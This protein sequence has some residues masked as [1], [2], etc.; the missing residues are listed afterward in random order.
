[1]T[2][3]TER[4]RYYVEYHSKIN[5]IS[6]SVQVPTSGV[7]CTI[8]SQAIDL[9]PT[10]HHGQDAVAIPDENTERIVLPA[11]VMPTRTTL[12][13]ASSQSSLLTLKLTAL[14]NAPLSSP[15]SLLTSISATEFPLAPLPATQLQGFENLAC[16][17]CGN[18]L[19][20]RDGGIDLNEEGPIKRVVDLP[21][22]HWQEL[23][24]CWMCHEE[25]Y[26]ELREGDLGARL[27]Q[28]L[29]G[30]TYVLIHAENVEQGAVAIEEDACAIDWAK[31]I[32]RRWRPLGCSRC[33]H[34]IGDGWYQSR[35]ED[36]TD[37][38]MIQAKFHKYAV[39]FKG[40]DEKS[41]MNLSVP[42]Q[43][44]ASYVAAEIFE[45]ARHHATYRFILQD[46]LDGQDMMLEP[47][48]DNQITWDLSLE[49]DL[50]TSSVSEHKRGKKVMKVL[51]LEALAEEQEV[52]KESYPKEIALWDNWR[53]D[54]GVE[55]LQFN[56]GLLLGLLTM[57]EQSSSC[58]PP[59]LNNAASAVLAMN[60]M[61][62]GRWFFKDALQPRN[63][64]SFKQ[65]IPQ[66][67]MDP[68]KK[69]VGFAPDHDI[70]TAD[71]PSPGSSKSNS[72]VNSPKSA[73]S[74][75]P[76]LSN[77]TISTPNTASAAT[78]APQ[79]IST[80]GARSSYEPMKSSYEEQWGLAD[81]GSKANKSGSP[82]DGP[83]FPNKDQQGGSNKKDNKSK[84]N[85]TIS[86]S[87][88]KDKASGLGIQANVITASATDGTQ[89]GGPN[90]AGS[91]S[92]GGPS[93]GGG[94]SKA[95]GSQ[96]PS[97]PSQKSMTK[98]ERRE[99][100][101]RKIAE[102]AARVSAG[103]PASGKKAAQVA[104]QPNSGFSPN[105]SKSL[106]T[107][108]PGAEAE[109]AIAAAESTSQAK[110]RE[111]L[112][113]EMGLFAHLD[114]PKFANTASA[115]KDLHPAVV[116]VGLQMAQFK[117][118]GANARCVAT[119]S[120]FRK[121]IQDYQTPP[122][123]TLS[124]NMLTYLSPHISYL[125]TCRPMAVSMGNAIR[126]LKYEIGK[127]LEVPDEDA[128]ALFLEKIDN[129][130]R[131]RITMADQ[132]ITS[133]GLQK[134]QDGDVI[135]TYARSSV[136]Q[137]LLLAAHEKGIKFK[138]IVVDSRPR[139]EGKQLLR[140]LA[141]AGVPCT[142][143]LLTA[144]GHVM[145]EVSKVILGAHSLLSNGA[146]YSRAGTAV[147][148]MS[149]H[150]RKIPVI[151]CCE[152]YKFSDRVQLDSFVQNEIGNPD[153]LV[154]DHNNNYGHSSTRFHE[155]VHGNSSGA[156]SSA[157]VLSGWKESR[158]L[159]LL[160]LLYDL[161]PSEF[162]TVVITEVGLIPCTSV[163]VILREFL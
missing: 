152:T 11:R 153:E 104:A 161:T 75:T 91:S 102:K 157:G 83:G 144:I 2:Q 137:D 138:V 29:I 14:P 101:E 97:A 49:S 110:K 158:D 21:S 46:R 154:N 13:P 115:P 148:A 54:P 139:F 73:L 58:L 36:G 128:R 122:N 4:L 18:V 53:G 86:T 7:T 24:D 48:Y 66:A 9:F 40:R 96:K 100:Q 129:F 89:S 31:G 65:D 43:R 145:R 17:C 8:G 87:G 59:A 146:L 119:L 44:F 61:R 141:S 23:V 93:S 114:P 50:C 26:T 130:I 84:R 51:Y 79:S 111:K 151:V 85:S 32:K 160:N 15:S 116:N 20:K 90:S 163:P 95:G 37:L 28:A 60:S 10:N 5:S 45:S 55:K 117:I 112:T 56:K 64:T 42:K 106:A 72:A 80:T 159:K 121:A 118:C 162:V 34:P 132:V 92:A 155:S 27:G 1:M 88:G 33:M 134:I 47:I 63:S 127:N 149:A 136:V 98:A 71:L 22:E 81:R 113:K 82:R 103:L 142:Y 147:V 143:V 140:A 126:Y 30:G 150:E 124:R 109:K 77:S 131:D 68:K 70:S 94:A 12:D 133:L 3:P 108:F 156:G 39:E 123:T 6:L 69:T 41:G 105:P 25:D 135:L 19:L 52:N 120:A 125:V 76:D 35:L 38:E 78:T 99:L 67:N 57:L 62:F 74:N 107:S 16:G